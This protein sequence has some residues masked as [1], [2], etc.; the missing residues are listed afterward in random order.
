[1][2]IYDRE[3]Q[4]FTNLLAALSIVGCKKVDICD[5][6]LNKFMPLLRDKVNEEGMFNKKTDVDA[7]YFLFM[8]DVDGYYS[9]MIY[10]MN[11]VKSIALINEKDSSLDLIM[12]EKTALKILE[13]RFFSTDSMMSIASQMLPIIE[14]S[15]KVKVYEINKGLARV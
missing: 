6:N 2:K 4:F 5:N 1:M 13:K 8:K 11:N 14:K 15:E 3:K 10:L 9:D 12:D 7:L